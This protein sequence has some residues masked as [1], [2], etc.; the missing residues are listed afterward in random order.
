MQRLFQSGSWLFVS[1]LSLLLLVG[2]CKTGS[3]QQ[4]GESLTD[5]GPR[6]P[7]FFNEIPA[8]TKYVYTGLEPFPADTA[9]QL[10]QRANE[11][12]SHTPVGLFDRI[13]SNLPDQFPMLSALADELEGKV[14]PEGLRE[15]GFALEADFAVYGL[16]GIPAVRLE[17]DDPEAFRGMLNR[18]ET[19]SEADVEM[20]E[21]QGT[22]YRLYGAG[23][24]LV[25]PVVV[26]E[27]AVVTTASPVEHSVHEVIRPYLLGHEEPDESLADIDEVREVA[28][29]YGYEKFGIGYLDLERTIEV[30]SGAREPDPLTAD[31]ME[32]TGFEPRDLSEVCAD[33][34]SE[35]AS[36]MPRL[37]LGI[38]ELS[39]SS[40]QLHGG[41]EIA[42]EYSQ[43]VAGAVEPVP[44][45]ESE[46]FEQA[47]LSVGFGLD[48]AKL[49]QV[50]RNRAGNIAESPYECQRFDEV[51]QQARR[52]QDRPVPPS[53]EQ[54]RGVSIILEGMGFRQGRMMP[55][56]IEAIAIVRTE[57]PQ[58]LMGRL[59]SIVPGLMQADIKDDGVPVALRQLDQMFDF[60]KSPHIAMNED[61]IA[62]S[63]G[64][65]MQDEMGAI[66]EEGTAPSGSMT[67]LA[68]GYNLRKIEASLPDPARDVL[69]Q[70]VGESF[71]DAM[72]G[73]SA[74]EIQ[75]T[76]RG[77][78]VESRSQRETGGSD[79]SRRAG[80]EA[81]GGESAKSSES[82]E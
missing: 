36:S 8:D 63:T 59:Q 6:V 48:V 56:N 30:S 47:A 73:S 25:V 38:Q 46:L 22:T 13:L 77:V 5:D 45:R 16:G 26:R 55:N 49:T 33:E 40:L 39:N 14:N 24:D 44:A 71:A 80:A 67:A 65:G 37:V 54:L 66:L 64:V 50:L 62:F 76:G 18:I 15:L 74:V 69:R 31:V 11:S 1:C 42:S 27:G 53:I 81:G 9:E 41:L 7:G 17:L 23:G 70:L 60:V 2:G 20:K 10:L 28:D 58:A 3:S 32:A 57:N 68:L 52:V 72:R 43:Q 19:E 12:G 78:F 79:E 82:G 4:S 29:S 21:F 75:V 51:N 35:V 61:V 34:I